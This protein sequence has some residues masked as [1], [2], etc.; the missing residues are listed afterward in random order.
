MA[1]GCGRV[2]EHAEGADG[3]S[4]GLG[5]S[6]C[7]SPCGT[8]NFGGGGHILLVEENKCWALV[9]E[10]GIWDVAE[11]AKSLDVEKEDGWAL[12]G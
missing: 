11:K 12:V 5:I 8:R 10:P 6:G 3:G 1:K 2:R 9:E 4:L 7:S